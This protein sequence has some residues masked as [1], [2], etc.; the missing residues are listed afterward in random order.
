MKAK[1]AYGIG[2]FLLT[3]PVATRIND[4]FFVHGGV[5]ELY[6]LSSLQKKIEKDVDANG[7]GADILLGDLGV[8]N[9]RMKPDVWWETS[10]EEPEARLH[11]LLYTLGV[12]HLAFGHQANTYHFSDGTKRK[13]G[14]MYQKF[15][16][17]FLID[18]GMSSA[19]DYSHGSLLHI[20]TNKQG[21]EC[22]TAL[23][24]DKSQ[25]VLWS[26]DVLE[27]LLS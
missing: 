1:D 5:P 14:T 23:Y 6:S 21:G 19:I 7:Y 27:P 11:D 3:L 10:S 26:E 22:A 13:K 17:V 2:Q 4:W 16:L 12:K 8:L 9:V 24:L 18:V 20:G 15:G 25:V